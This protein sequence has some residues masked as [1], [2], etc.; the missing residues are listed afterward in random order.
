MKAASYLN[1]DRAVVLIIG[2][3]KVIK[4]ITE[5]FEKVQK[6]QGSI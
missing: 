6:I 1:P 4:E 2:N 5:C 3:E